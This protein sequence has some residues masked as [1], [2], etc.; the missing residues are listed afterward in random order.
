MKNLYLIQMLVLT[1][2]FA[3]SALAQRVVNIPQ[4]TDVFNPMDIFPVIMGDTTA[5]GERVDNNTIYTLDNG[6]VYVTSGRIVNKP[7]WDLQIQAVDLENTESKPII[8]RL[9]NASGSF[10]DIMRPEGNVTIRNLW[11]VAGE[12]GALEQHDWGKIR[13]L[14]ENTRI[15]AEDCIIEKD[16]GGFFQIRAAGIKL[17]ITN[18]ILRNGGNRRILQGNGRGVDARNF[19]LDSLVMKNTIVHNLQD[20][21]FRSQGAAEPHKYIEIDNCTA[22]NVAGRHGF[23]QLGRVETAKI[24][25][26]LFINPIMLGSSPIY[27]DEQ[28]QP[29]GDLHKVITV[30]TLYENTNLMITNN[31]IFWTQDVQDY[32][33]SNDTV[34]APGVLSELVMES[35]GDAADDAFFQ[36]LLALNNVPGTIL[37]YVV[38]LYNNPSAEDMFDF[39]VE[40]V[41]LNGTDFDSGNLFDFS[42]FDPCYDLETASASASTSGGAIGAVFLCPDLLSSTFDAVQAKALNFTSFPNPTT[43]AIQMN[44][45]LEQPSQV[46]ILVTDLSG[47]TL[48]TLLQS[49]LQA[50]AHNFTFDIAD[51][52][53]KGMYI[54]SLRTDQGW[55]TQKM[56]VK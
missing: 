41:T 47:R 54:L 3:S 40:D 55:T 13:Y 12:K 32:W 22:F 39:I 11:I 36:E 18:C 33:A 20:R 43:A 8:S 10:P 7:E 19:P 38:D 56:V 34:S 48:A 44:F 45:E 42:A 28:T 9:P 26:N 49:K 21:F 25:D 52:L 6:A 29:D 53:P 17:Y 2:L 31:N 23:I 27:T 30:D 24:T 1:V 5:T 50:G 16:R 15:I 37:Q 14:G 4:S 35:L 46:Q 51:R